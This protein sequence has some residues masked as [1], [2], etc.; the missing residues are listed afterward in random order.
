MKAYARGGPRWRRQSLLV[1]TALSM[2]DEDA[3]S[4]WTRDSIPSAE[5][6]AQEGKLIG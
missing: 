2:V 4:E 1:Q 5:K 6:D 3:R